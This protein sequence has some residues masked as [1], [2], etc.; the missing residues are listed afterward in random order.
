MGLASRRLCASDCQSGGRL[1]ICWR[2]RRFGE[3]VTSLQRVVMVAGRLRAPIRR[4]GRERVFEDRRIPFPSTPA[5][6]VYIYIPIPASGPFSEFCFLVRCTKVL[7]VVSE[8][9]LL[10][11]ISEFLHLVSEFLLLLGHGVAGYGWGFWLVTVGCGWLR[12]R[13]KV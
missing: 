4:S 1:P 2:F 3:F 9:L 13:L 11:L 10:Y 8:F 5:A 6:L 7:V 12:V